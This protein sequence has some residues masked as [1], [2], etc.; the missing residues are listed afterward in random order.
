MHRDVISQI[1]ASPINDLLITGSIDGH[2]KFWRKTFTLLEPIRTFKA[3]SGQITGISLSK[4]QDLLATVGI[5]KIVRIFDTKACDLKQSIK[6]HFVPI[7]CE[8]IPPRA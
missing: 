1:I 6:L 4:N 7:C 2:I 5:D 8:F 3:H